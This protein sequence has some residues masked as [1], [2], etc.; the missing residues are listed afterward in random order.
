ME[1]GFLNYFTKHLILEIQNL[2]KSAEKIER[3]N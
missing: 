3:I 1:R 2:R